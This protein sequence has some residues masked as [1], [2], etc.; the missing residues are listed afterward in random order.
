M[1][2]KTN[3]QRFKELFKVVNGSI[4]SALLRER[5]VKVMDMTIKDIKE[6]P[7]EWENAFVHPS[8]YE[9]LNE[10]VQKYIGFND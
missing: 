10:I 4:Y 6:N 9:E 5:I 2:T 8:M 3:D 1:K 7:E